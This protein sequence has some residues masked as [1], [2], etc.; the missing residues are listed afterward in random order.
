MREKIGIFEGESISPT[1]MICDR[2]KLHKENLNVKSSEPNKQKVLDSRRYFSDYLAKGTLNTEICT[3]IEKMLNDSEKKFEINESYHER[4]LE[5]M[6][7]TGYNFENN[8][9]LDYIGIVSGEVV[10]GT[11]I[12]S[13]L[14]A[15]LSDILGAN[16]SSYQSKL[17]QC[18]EATMQIITEKALQLGA[19][20]IIGV[21][22]DIMTIGNNMIVV[23]ANGTAVI[24]KKNT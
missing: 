4:K 1:L 21:D 23:S 13:D 18:K 2:C 16:A 6:A 12:I 5:F 8:K 20:A 9:I 22:F 7:T 3:I 15:T 10:L 11:G 19:N 14:G 24:I 17:G